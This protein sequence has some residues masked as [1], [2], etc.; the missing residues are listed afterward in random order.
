MFGK[1][2][3]MDNCIHNGE[4]KDP[5]ELVPGDYYYLV[6]RDGTEILIE[7]C[8]LGGL[9]PYFGCRIWEYRGNR[10]AS[11]RWR[12]FRHKPLSRNDFD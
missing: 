1:E 3:F 10:Q 11:Q 9:N 5:S 7:K 6:P 12:I 8:K 4:I 2:V